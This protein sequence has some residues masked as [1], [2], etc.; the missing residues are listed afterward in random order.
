MNEYKLFNAFHLP[1]CVTGPLL[2][3]LPLRKQKYVI[4]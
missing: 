2:K 3:C 1:I 4:V